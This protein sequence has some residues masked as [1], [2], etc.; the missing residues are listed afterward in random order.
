MLASAPGSPFLC[1]HGCATDLDCLA[2]NS[3]IPITGGA[4][5]HV[6]MPGSPVAGGQPTYASCNGGLTCAT[7]TCI[8]VSTAMTTG[9][10]FCS[11]ICSSSSECAGVGTALGAACLMLASAPSSPFVCYPGCATDANCQAGTSC[12]PITGGAV[13]HVCMPGTAVAAARPDYDMCA[14][15]SDCQSDVCALTTVT[16]TSG[17]TLSGHQCTRACAS[18]SECGDR[19]GMGAACLMIAGTAS[20]FYCYQGCTLDSDCPGVNGVC[21]PVTGGAVGHV[22]FPQ[23]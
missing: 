5:G 9:G 19:N 2:G 6:C 10:S 23:D 12:I 20:A 3:C 7:D 4:V 17:G 16:T 13:G 15:S 8:S 11:D 14:V 18:S 22:C 21:T 1:Y